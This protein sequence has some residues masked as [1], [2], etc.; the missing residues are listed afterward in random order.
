MKSDLNLALCCVLYMTPA[1]GCLWDFRLGIGSVV[2]TIVLLVGT[3][4][5]LASLETERE[6]V[7]GALALAGLCGNFALVDPP[8]GPWGLWSMATF[9]GL[10]LMI[11]GRCLWVL[12]KS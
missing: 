9:I 12:K 8:F 5:A 3:V 6:P 2:S 4:G 7:F 11:C 1:I 10:S